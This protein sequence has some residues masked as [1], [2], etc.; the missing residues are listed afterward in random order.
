MF[1][2]TKD[3]EITQDGKGF[4]K[5]KLEDGSETGRLR[6]QRLFPITEGNSYIRMVSPDGKE[7]GIIKSLGELKPESRENALNALNHFYIIPV[8]TEIISL[9]DAHGS[10]FWEV[11]TDKGVR[12][13]VVANRYRD[14]SILPSGK[15]VIRDTDDNQYEITDYNKF[16]E[17]SRKLLEPWL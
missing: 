7:Y 11:R 1:L 9:Y 13:F 4:I 16:P 14:V 5:L 3:V 10:L 6:L 17:K 2:D 15:M 12:K 8:I